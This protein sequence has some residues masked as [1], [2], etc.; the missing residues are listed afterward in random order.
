MLALSKPYVFPKPKK[1]TILTALRSA[2]MMDTAIAPD[3]FRTSKVR[4]A[5]L[6][7]KARDCLQDAEY[8]AQA[9]EVENE[10]CQA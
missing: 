8:S 5:A 9:L 3:H 6:L 7:G 1:L 2:R 4:A 10:I